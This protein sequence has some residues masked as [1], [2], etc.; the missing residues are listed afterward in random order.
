MKAPSTPIIF[1]AATAGALATGFEAYEIDLTLAVWN[2][3]PHRPLLTGAIFLA[4]KAVP[5]I[6]LAAII[7]LTLTALHFRRKGSPGTGTKEV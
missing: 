6:S 5:W 2:I 7:T 3:A 1:A 4:I